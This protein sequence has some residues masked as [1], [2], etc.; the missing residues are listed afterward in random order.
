MLVNTRQRL[1]SFRWNLSYS[2]P[3]LISIP[4]HGWRRRENSLIENRMAWR[5]MWGKIRVK[6]AFSSGWLTDNS[7]CRGYWLHALSNHIQC[8]KPQSSNVYGRQTV[9]SR[10]DHRL[11]A[12]VWYSFPN[13]R[14]FLCRAVLQESGNDGHW[15]FYQTD[16]RYYRFSMIYMKTD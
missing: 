9:G 14:D 10:G 4:S 8:C 3:L 1:V 13:N 2:T 6:T 7:K 11:Y 12:S 16:F 5:T 15:P